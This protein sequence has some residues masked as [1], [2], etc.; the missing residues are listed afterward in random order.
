MA[1]RAA[2]QSRARPA[3]GANADRRRCTA[4]ENAGQGSEVDHGGEGSIRCKE[5]R[6]RCQTLRPL[7]P[8][9]IAFAHAAPD[10]VKPTVLAPTSR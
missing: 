5:T 2:V 4:R 6:R 9:E 10:S 7:T 1:A 8:Q 3:D